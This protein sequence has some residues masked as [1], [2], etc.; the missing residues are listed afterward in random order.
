MKFL[1]LTILLAVATM[2]TA[3]GQKKLD[4]S[5]PEDALK[6][7]RKVQASMKDGENCIFYWTGAVYSR[8]PQEPIVHPEFMT[9]PPLDDKRP[10]ETSWTYFKK[11]LDKKGK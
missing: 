5:N 9:A 2:T 8:V 6:A 4:L 3:V 7:T 10:N 11:W 1:K